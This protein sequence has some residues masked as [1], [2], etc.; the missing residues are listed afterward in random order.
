MKVL[1]LSPLPP[2]VGGIATWTGLALNAAELDEEIAVELQDTAVKG[3][4]VIAPSLVGKVVIGGAQAVMIAISFLWRCVARRPNV[5]HLCTPTDLGLVRDIVLVAI[6]RALFIPVVVHFHRGKV[7]DYPE[8]MSRQGSF[9]ALLVRA[10][11]YLSHRVIVLNDPALV[12]LSPYGG[13]KLTILANMVDC[14]EKTL[15]TTPLVKRDSTATHVL[16]VGHVV[17]RKGILDLVSACISLRESSLDIRLKVVGPYVDEFRDRIL[18]LAGA[19][20]GSG[21]DWL[22]FTGSCGPDKV[23]DEM[24]RAD[25]FCLPSYAEGFPYVILEAMAVGL[26]IISTQVGA[27]P[28]ALAD[29]AGVCIQPGDVGALASEIGRLSV[30]NQDAFLM[31]LRAHE[32]CKKL[33][34]SS[35]IFGRLKDEWRRVAKV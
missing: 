2:P 27:M 3:R 5:I 20:T 24:K 32:K 8:L 23:K 1:L 21:T 35:A 13:S 10:I 17:E 11:I 30:S 4:S 31:G 16:F 19:S 34:S 9:E 26:P 33:Y 29:G 15:R 28:Q 12:A 18:E 14:S 25:I 6:A 7:P 22:E